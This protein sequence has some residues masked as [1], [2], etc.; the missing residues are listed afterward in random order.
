MKF[1]LHRMLTCRRKCIDPTRDAHMHPIGGFGPAH[2]SAASRARQVRLPM[3]LAPVLIS[4]FAGSGLSQESYNTW[5]DSARIYL[6]TGASGANSMYPVTKFPVLVRLD[7]SNFPAFDSTKAGGADIRFAKSNG[8]HLYYSIERWVDTSNNMDIADIWVK[9]DSVKGNDTTQYITMYW[10]KPSAFDSSKSQ[11]V[12][13]TM[14]GYSAA[15]HLTGG[16]NDATINALNGVN[17]GTL[18]S[19][20]MIGKA[21]YFNGSSNYISV[22]NSPAINPTSAITISAWINP[23]VWGASQM[24]R[25]VAKGNSDNQYFLGE[26]SGVADSLKFGLTGPSPN[27]LGVAAPS[28]SVW[29]HIAG[30]YTPGTGMRLYVDG[31]KV[32]S[33]AATGTLTTTSDTLCIGFRKNGSAS[34]YFNG[35]IDEVQISKIAR[36]SNWVKLAFENQ[37]AGQSL[38][39]MNVRTWTNV[40]GNFKWNSANNWKPPCV[41][42]PNDSVVFSSGAATCTLDVSTTVNAIVFTS[43]YAGSFVFNGKTLS[44]RSTADFRSNGSFMKTGIDTIA[45]IGSKMQIFFPKSGGPVFPTLWKKGTGIVV[46]QG[47]G[48]K[49][50]ALKISA[51][52]FDFGYNLVDSIG[53]NLIVNGGRF[54]FDSATVRISANMVDFNFLDSIMP[55]AGTLEFCGSGS[56]RTFTPKAGLQHPNILQSASCTTMVA[57]NDLIAGKVKIASGFFN[58][59]NN[60]RTLT[61]AGLVINGGQLIA[62]NG[63]LDINGPDSMIAGMLIAPGSGKSFALS[64]NFVRSGG[65]FAHSSGKLTLDGA[66][67]K[68]SGSTTFYRLSKV[69]GA[70]DSLTFEASMIDSVLDSCVLKGTAGQLLSLRSSSS[71][72]QW[73]LAPSTGKRDIQYVDVKDGNNLITP[74]I[75]PMNSISSGNNANWFV[76]IGQLLAGPN[77]KTRSG[78]IISNQDS[79]PLLHIRMK[80]D[81]IEPLYLDTLRLKLKK[82]SPGKVSWMRL[83]MDLDRSGHVSA[84][85]LW[86]RDTMVSGVDSMA[87]FTKGGMHL[88]TVQAND[89]MDY[90]I[91]MKASSGIAASDTFLANCNPAQTRFYGKQSFQYISGTGSQ[92][93]GDTARGFSGPITWNG[94][95]S[96]CKW[97]TAGNWSGSAVP[98]STDSVVFNAT[99]TK[100]CSLDVNVSIKS[101]AMASGY[102]GSFSFCG[103]TLSITSCADFSSNGSINKT[104]TDTLA[105]TGSG[106]QVFIP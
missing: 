58:I 33:N 91:V 78:N 46:V 40:G 106:P 94:A 85:D 98:I 105:F 99:S 4:I 93:D 79:I 80:A 37:K 23:S 57:T 19:M 9:V 77:N 103:R 16:F 10:N 55:G 89:S 21:R 74:P 31:A 22:L 72:T 34:H 41:P 61:A 32:A 2:P 73:K 63:N 1:H 84:G 25:V 13:D 15:W 45:F 26:V 64:G 30:T 104:G 49:A 75:N 51:G 42:G 86:L 92:F 83:Y 53:M 39:K 71:S 56:T 48:F 66:Y 68:I 96:D 97:N 101:I 12:F 67:Q 14:D 3:L 28:T 60:S 5:G 95:G 44:I 76:G 81:N 38:V 62:T 87:V 69:V 52:V 18:D 17:N 82:G 43:G 11:A 29:H 88:D 24:R 59:S 35:T 36:D 70:A 47:A 7:P 20:G 100:S 102:T 54:N 8:T 65:T 6:N 50:D 27:A 90:V